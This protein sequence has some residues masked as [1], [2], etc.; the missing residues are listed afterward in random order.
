MDRYLLGWS[1]EWDQDLKR[2]PGGI[3]VRITTRHKGSYKCVTADG[4][5]L[6]CY[7]PG[8]ILRDRVTHEQV[9]NTA[10][11]AAGDWCIAGERFVDSSNEQAVQVVELI[12]RRSSISRMMAGT[13]VDEQ[14]LAANVDIAFIV[15]SINRDFSIN[16]LRRYV[17][18]AQQGGVRPIVV[19][20]KV[21]LS[22]TDCWNCIDELQTSL[23][24]VEHLQT[25]A[26]SDVGIDRIDEILGPGRTAVFLGSSGVGKSTLVNSLLKENVQRTGQ[27]AGDQTGRHVTSGASLF[28]TRS[29]GI[30]IDTAGL[31]EVQICVDNDELDQLMPTVSA[32]A[33]DCKFSDC[34]HTVEPG[35]N[36]LAGLET[37]QLD[38][39]EFESYVQ[40]E[41]E[42]NYARRKLDQRFASDERKRWKQITRDNRARTKAREGR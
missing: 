32:L 33:E 18:I 3:L 31:R 40:L 15:T 25:S 20:S 22:Q 11:P 21:D 41:K 2:L 30:V 26:V 29:G 17:L 39:S 10:L 28:F 35:C 12:P 37:K 8:K 27:I 1:P 4:V 19:L 6:N 14:V 42:A 23:P 5:M 36:V 7:L 13:A 9:W 38:Q 34:T 16:R 24:E